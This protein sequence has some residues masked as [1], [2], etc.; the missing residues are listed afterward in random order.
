MVIDPQIRNNLTDVFVAYNYNSASGYRE[1][2]VRYQ[3]NG[4]AL[5]NPQPILDNI[6][7]ASIHNG[8]R[9]IITPDRKL[10]ITTG[11]AATTSTSQ[12]INSINGKV[13]R[14]NLDG[15]IPSDNPFGNNPAWSWGHRN[16]QGLIFAPLHNAI[17]SSEHGQNI[18]DE[19]NII[20]KGRNYGW[21][22]VEGKCDLTAEQTFCRDSNVVEPISGWTPTLGVAGIDFYNSNH[23]PEWKNSILMTSLKGARLTVIKLSNDGKTAV[24]KTDYYTNVYG[25]LRD[26]C[27]SPDGKVYIAVSNRDTRGVPKAD[28]DKIIEISN[29]VSSVK[30]LKNEVKIYPNPTKAH[31]FIDTENPNI[32]VTIYDSLGRDIFQTKGETTISTSHLKNGL[33][34]VHVYDE[35]NQLIGLEKIIKL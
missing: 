1:R 4:S 24:S 13:L 12:N 11:D 18:E 26:V 29:A 33:Y 3:F 34:F 23:I 30:D 21:V 7:A 19:L 22:R 16:A 31:I 9:M 6:N 2:I 5:I 15:T 10:F 27:V 35:D 25:R 32:R 28:D 14:L 8:C 20:L 17:Y